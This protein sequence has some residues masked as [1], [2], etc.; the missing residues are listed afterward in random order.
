MVPREPIADMLAAGM[1]AWNCE[2][3]AEADVNAIYTA[4]IAAHEG[5]G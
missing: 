1:E 3:C 5:E 2:D 4:M